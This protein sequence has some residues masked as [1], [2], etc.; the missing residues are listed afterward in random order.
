MNLL[1]HRLTLSLTL[2]AAAACWAQT[3]ANTTP[4]A[5]AAAPPE[6][7]VAREPGVSARFY[8]FDEE[9]DRLPALVEGQTP[10]VSVKL[11]KIELRSPADFAGMKERFLSELSGFLNVSTPGEYTFRLFSDDG[12]ALRINGKLVADNDG[13][14]DAKTGVQGKIALTAGEH[15]FVLRHFDMSYDE[16]IILQWR[17]PGSENW[18][19]VP[20]SVFTCPANEVR[21]T[22]PG[23][24]RIIAQGRPSGRP[25]DARPLAAVHPSFDLFQARPENFQPRVGGIDFLP[26]GR[27]IICTWDPVGGVYILSGQQGNDPSQIKVKRFAAGLAEPLGIRVVD[28]RVFVLQ[29]QELTELIDHDKDEVADEYRSVSSAWNV[30]ANFHEFA[31]GLVHKDNAFYAALAVAID[32]GGATTK[33]QVRGRGTVLKINMDGTTEVFA[34]GV[35]TPNG[36]ALGPDDEIL[37]AD[38]Q[39][40]WLP[41]SK[42]LAIREGR[43]YNSHLNP[44]HPNA[45]LPP[46]PPIVWL[47]QNELANSPSEPLLL[48]SGPYQGQV[49][50]GDVTHGGLNRVFMEKVNNEWQGAAFQFSQGF[51]G[52]VNRLMQGPDGAIYVGQIGSSGNWGQSGKK[53]YGLQRITPNDKVAFEPKAVRVRSDGF[54]V[55][56]TAPLAGGLGE[57]PS[58]YR[59][60]QWRYQPAR[61]YGGPKIDERRLEVTGVALNEDRTKAFI[62]MAGMLPGHVVYLRLGDHLRSAAGE[63]LWVTEAWYTLNQIPGDLPGPKTVAPPPTNTLS[64]AEKAQGWRLLFDGQNTA[65]WRGYRKTEMA[66]GWQ[67]VDGTLARL[68]GGGDIITVD[69]FDDFELQ[70]EWRISEGGNSGLFYRVNEKLPV[71][72]QSGPEMQVLDNTRHAD[73]KNPLTSAGSAYAVLPPAKDVTLPVGAW[74]RVRLVVRGNHVE[75]WLNNEKVVEYELNSPEWKAAVQKSKFRDVA[76]YGQEKIGHLVL[77]DHGDAVWYRN[78]KIRPLTKPE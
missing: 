11:D 55:E 8:Q 65:Q 38:N 37:V 45:N 50:L 7:S 16:Q 15:P 31:F 76:G 48:R 26:D 43:F 53:S 14:H 13:L 57:D 21:V 78:I 22:A 54:E 19:V 59:V 63:K 35:R 72:W 67:V 23:V 29:K 60:Q 5:P 41:S 39:G 58:D 2:S 68:G 70:L 40:D 18:E 74:N 44:D 61:T 62:K 33:Q 49:I 20:P 47:P 32:P 4:S 75:H 17:T 9:I 64:E 36:I 6:A 66:A 46:T 73:G 27:M 34:T 42:L 56:F 25:G 52:G 28:G 12:S 3:P 51:E 1:I 30:S 24:K 69:Q 77:Q 71:G 10:N